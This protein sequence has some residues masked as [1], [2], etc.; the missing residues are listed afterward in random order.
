MFATLNHEPSP[1][2]A[3]TPLCEF[4]ARAKLVCLQFISPMFA[5]EQLAGTD[6][7]TSKVMTRYTATLRS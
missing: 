4:L 1:V 3:S 6:Q 5:S 7:N 2:F